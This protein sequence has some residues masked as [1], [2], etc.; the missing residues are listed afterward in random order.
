M[1]RVRIVSVSKVP[2]GAYQ[3]L[4]ENFLKFLKSFARV[5]MIVVAPSRLQDRARA[6]AEEEARLRSAVPSDS[7]RVVLEATGVQMTSTSFAKWTQRYEDE[8]Q[9]LCFVIGGP[10]GLSPEFKKEADVLLS[11]SLFTLPHDLAQIVLLEQL[12]RALTIIHKKTYH[13]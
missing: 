10:F 6:I 5:E 4:Q 12:Y 13:Y 11:L 3:E 7:V 1:L 9:E 2:R 8:G